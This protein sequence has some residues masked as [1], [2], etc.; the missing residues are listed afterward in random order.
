MSGAGWRGW[1]LG[2]VTVGMAVAA[3]V[4][5]AIPQ[6]LSYHAF[7]DCRTFWAIPNFLNVASNVP[8]L[9]GGAMGL[10]LIWNGGG[11]FIDQREQ[12]PYLVFFLGA[13]LTCFGSAYYH[14]EPDNPRLVWD[15]LPMTL[16]FAGLVSAAIAERFDLKLGLRAL[17]PLL[18]LGV[19][20]VIYWYA[21]ELAGRGNIIPYA[22]YQAWSIVAIVLLIA[23]FPARRYSHGS[24][25]V[26]AAVWYGLA[27]IFE[28]FDLQVYRLLQGTLSGHTIKHV[29]AAGAVFAVVRQLQRRS[30][31]PAVNIATAA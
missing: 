25:L 2:A 15:R 27:K 5:P 24:L 19:V 16:G 4:V 10:M 12:L 11:R 8:F 30:A 21:T 13:F 23:V 7:A 17:W 3:I 14:A 9:V 29:L 28:T 20:T 22:A 18:L 1:L 26:W 6:P 31:L